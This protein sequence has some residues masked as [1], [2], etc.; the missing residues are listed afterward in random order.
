MERGKLLRRKALYL[1]K[2]YL[3]ANSVTEEV[4]KK[5]T[6]GSERKKNSCWRATTYLRKVTG[7]AGLIKKKGNRVGGTSR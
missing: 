3:R 5:G 1:E 4:K 2:T 6:G 7:N